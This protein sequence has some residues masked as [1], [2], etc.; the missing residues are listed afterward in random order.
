MGAYPA[1]VGRVQGKGFRYQM[2]V[3]PAVVLEQTRKASWA[4]KVSHPSADQMA[5]PK[6]NSESVLGMDWAGLGN[7]ARVSDRAVPAVALRAAG[8][9]ALA[10]R[11]CREWRGIPTHCTSAVGCTPRRKFHHYPKRHLLSRRL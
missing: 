8:H 9:A 6:A 3:D 11:P 4:R 7:P 10:G 2:A 1:Q 5:K